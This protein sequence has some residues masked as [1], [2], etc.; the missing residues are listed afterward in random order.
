MLDDELKGNLTTVVKFVVM[1]VAPYFGVAEA[2]RNELVSVAL[3]GV[4]LALAYLDA[5][6]HNTIIAGST[7]NSSSDGCTNEVCDSGVASDSGLC[8]SDSSSIN[9]SLS[10]NEEEEMLTPDTTVA[11]VSEAIKNDVGVNEAVT[12]VSESILKDIVEKE[13]QE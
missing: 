5:K 11:N 12:G 9:D 8:F 13:E 6:H 1:T 2:T 3:A 10:K 7:D 4:G